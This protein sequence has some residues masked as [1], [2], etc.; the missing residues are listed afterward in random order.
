MHPGLWA[1]PDTGGWN[2]LFWSLCQKKVRALVSDWAS[3]S[4]PCPSTQFCTILLPIPRTAWADASYTSM[5]CTGIPACPVIRTSRIQ[6]PSAKRPSWSA[7]DGY[8][9]FILCLERS[10]WSNKAWSSRS[11]CNSRTGIE[12]QAALW[13]CRDN[14]G[15]LYLICSI[16][17]SRYL[18]W[19]LKSWRTWH[20]LYIGNIGSTRIRTIL[21]ERKHWICSVDRENVRNM[22][23]LEFQDLQ[24]SFDEGWE[25]IMV[26]STT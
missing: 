23:Q 12:V 18:Q 2:C 4:V 16:P 7:N 20:L 6:R 8:E 22:V 24:R 15:H 3:P 17:A 9:F 1:D 26:I 11:T 10:E 21:F 13:L 5:P 25:R 19:H 14:P